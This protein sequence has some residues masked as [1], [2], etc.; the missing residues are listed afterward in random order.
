MYAFC[1]SGSLVCY[2]SDDP[3]FPFWYVLHIIKILLSEDSVAYNTA[4]TSKLYNLSVM[5]TDRFYF[6]LCF[7]QYYM[8][9]CGL[10][11]PD[12]NCCGG[13]LIKAN[14]NDFLISFVQA[15]TFPDFF[16]ADIFTSMSKVCPS[17][18]RS[19]TCSHF[20]LIWPT[21]MSKILYSLSI[22][23]DSLFFILVYPNIC[24]FTC[25]ICFVLSQTCPI[26]T[27]FIK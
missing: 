9:C 18:S 27:K 26:L 15:I 16:L 21:S 20:L 1:L 14:F 22:I 4:F 10:G 6:S 24:S 7:K 8:L 17:L 12:C 23:H 3:F 5:G 2:P 25:Y 13:I 11:F 19:I